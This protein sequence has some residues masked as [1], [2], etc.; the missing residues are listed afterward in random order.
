MIIIVDGIDRVGK[1]TLCNILKNT[2]N[3]PICKDDTRYLGSHENVIVNTEKNN[4]FVNLIEQGCLTN[5]IFDRFHL[6][7][8]VYSAIERN[9]QNSY[10]LD[11]DKRLAN[12]KTANVILILVNPVDV[13][14][15][16]VQH[17]KDLSEHAELFETFYNLSKI[18]HKYITNYD[19]F[20]EL[21]QKL[22]EKF[23][24]F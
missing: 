13:N 9:V 11:I 6:T 21:I 8:Y 24:C 17:G 22:Q 7:E 12:I 23:G 19:E 5:I 10:M 1:T 3:L 2:F 20:D 18:K 15:S 14:K 16:S 4:T